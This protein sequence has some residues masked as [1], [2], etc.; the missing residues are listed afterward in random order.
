MKRELN[1]LSLEAEPYGPSINNPPVCDISPISD[2]DYN[3]Y[4]YVYRTACIHIYIYVIVYICV[5]VYIDRVI[6]NTETGNLVVKNTETGN[7]V[8]KK[9]G[10]N[11]RLLLS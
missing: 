9:G 11:R 6:K 4:T 1:Y 8:V 7:L 3:K 2:A 5:N 10:A